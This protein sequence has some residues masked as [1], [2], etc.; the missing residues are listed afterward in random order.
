MIAGTQCLDQRRV[1]SPKCRL[2]ESELSIAGRG[3]GDEARCDERQNPP[4]V[5]RRDELPSPP[6]RV[7]PK[8]GAFREGSFDARFGDG[9][10]GKTATHSPLRRA[11]VLTLHGAEPPYD[12][13]W[14]S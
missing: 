12:S 2:V 9:I 1:A 13:A 7:G 8:Y 4:Y 11:I 3:A 10:S 6:K 14:A 5:G